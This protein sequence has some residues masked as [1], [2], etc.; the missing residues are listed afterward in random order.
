[1]SNKEEYIQQIIYQLL[2]NKKLL[3][4]K[5][6]LENSQAKFGVHLMKTVHKL[7]NRLRKLRKSL[8][9]IST[10]ASVGFCVKTKSTLTK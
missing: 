10:L 9:K 6:K 1:M 8:K 4:Y 7:S 3:C 5:K 2:K